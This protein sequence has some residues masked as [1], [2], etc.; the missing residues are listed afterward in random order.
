MIEV[1]LPPLC[2]QVT[3]GALVRSPCG[4]E[5]TRRS[6]PH[7]TRS[8]TMRPLKGLGWGCALAVL[9]ACGGPA[10]A[11]WNNVFQV[12]GSSG[13]APAPAVLT[14]FGGDPC[15]P[16]QQ[17]CTTRYVQRSY[18]QPVTTYKTTTYSVPVTTYRTSYYYEPV[19]SYRYTCAYNPCTC[20]YE[21][22]AQPVTSY[23]LRSQ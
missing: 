11:A 23:R 17:Q 22:V 9:A 1:A 20:R 13:S 8:Y 14:G 2:G 3:R 7:H 19:C 6:V 5:P 15:C 21:T 12:C 18:Y 4:T 16:P 10:H